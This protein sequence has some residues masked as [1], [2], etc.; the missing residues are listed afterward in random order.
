MAGIYIHIPF[1][2]QNCHY[3]DF[4]YS[5]SLRYKSQI[6]DALKDEIILRKKYLENEII[7]TIYFGGGTP[8]ILSLDDIKDV[9]STVSK[10]FRLSKSVEITLEA[11]PD[12]LTISYGIGLKQIGI[13]RISLGVQSFDDTDLTLM[14]R[15]HDS[16]KAEEAIHMLKTIPVENFSVDL[17]YAV[18]GSSEKTLIYN[19]NKVVDA[20]A[21][22]VSVYHLT[23]EDGTIFKHK[24]KKQ[25]LTEIGEEESNQ[26][27]DIIKKYLVSNGYL[28]YEI[29]NFAKDGFISKHNSSYWFGKK[30]LGLGPS[31]HSF[32]GESR[33]WNIA[34]LQK[35]INGIK[36]RKPIIEKETLQ[37]SVQYNEFLMV[38]L[39]TM[40]GVNHKELE[41]R[42]GMHQLQRF[43]IDTDYFIANGSLI[44][45]E[46][47]TIM[48][49]TKYLQSDHIISQ[50]FIM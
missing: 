14:N 22:H 21:S 4:Y 43:F 18:P 46:H 1:C 36:Q 15:R 3:C 32:N 20:G 27:Y 37:K 45:N 30:Y 16:N 13:N 49:P 11:N 26:Q 7:E 35:Y 19:L 31:A 5:I 40:W 42:F 24:V 25:R 9:L 47:E 17:I 34:A 44:R 50:L 29:S 41:T 48:N 8:S 12:D 2:R 28:H 10:Y 6:V 39:R 38:R 23:Y 33:Q